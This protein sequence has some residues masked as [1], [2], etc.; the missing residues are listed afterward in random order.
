[1]DVAIDQGGCFETSRPTSHANPVYEEAG[2]LHYCVTNIPSMVPRSASIAL[3]HALTP[4]LESVLRLGVERALAESHA[5]ADAVNI[6]TRSI[7]L[8]SLK[9]LPASA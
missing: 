9:E 6:R 2:V 1:V 7:V 5:L 4:Y 3:S 8:D